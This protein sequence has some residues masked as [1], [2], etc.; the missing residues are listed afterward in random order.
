MDYYSMSSMGASSPRKPIPVSTSFLM[1]S[2]WR[3]IIISSSSSYGGASSDAGTE[4]D[5]M[6]FAAA[7]AASANAAAPSA[8]SLTAAALL[9]A[10]LAFLGGAEGDGDEDDAMGLFPI[11]WRLRRDE[12]DSLGRSDGAWT[13]GSR[14]GRETDEVRTEVEAARKFDV[15]AKTGTKAK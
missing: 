11:L 9:A 10:S 5:A 12:R 7:N 4:V 2:W 1:S 13:T 8:A 3:G 15:E 14:G 6:A